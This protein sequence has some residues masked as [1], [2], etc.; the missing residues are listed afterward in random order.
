MRDLAHELSPAA[1]RVDRPKD[2]HEAQERVRTYLADL[3]ATAPR[4]GLGAATGQLID[5]LVAR[6]ERYG[7]HLFVCF[8]DGRIPATSNALEG[9]FGGAK[10]LLRHA[11]GSG[12]TTHSVV[13]NLGADVLLTYADCRSPVALARIQNLT[14]D[15]TRFR[16]VRAEI[17]RQEAPTI[18]RRSM[19]RHLDRQLDGLRRHWL[20]PQQAGGNA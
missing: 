20:D 17:T 3:A 13:G 14:P 12:N 11:L 16:E 8:E 15:A 5:T 6:T 19:V 9:F 18:R 1:D 4:A 7:A 2:A 10:R